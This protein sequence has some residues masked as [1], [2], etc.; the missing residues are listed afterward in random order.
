M[1]PKRKM[2]NVSFRHIDEFYDF[3]PE[4][5]LKIV[6]AI[7]KII[8]SCIP[9]VTEKLAYN[10]PFFYR[11]KRICFIWPPSVLWGNVRMGRV[12]LGFVNGYLLED[13]INYLEKEK[14]KQIYFHYFSAVKEIDVDLLKSY[15]YQAAIIDE[16]L[17]KTKKP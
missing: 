10:V 2:Q 16:E 3:L 5:E 15:I 7:R 4:E 12:Q 1:K 6:E 17:A 13:E 8:Y 11:H 14:R 9:G